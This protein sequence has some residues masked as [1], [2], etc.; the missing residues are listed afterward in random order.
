MKRKLKLQPQV[1]HPIRSPPL[2]LF[3]RT[4]V[5]YWARVPLWADET[6]LFVRP[7]CILRVLP[8]L[9][10]AHLLARGANLRHPMVAKNN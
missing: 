4:I 10:A 9:Q 7:L 2:V 1:T 5:N 3:E 6:A 8:R